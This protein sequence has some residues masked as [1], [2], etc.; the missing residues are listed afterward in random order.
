MLTVEFL[1]PYLNRTLLILQRSNQIPR[2]PKD[3]VRPKIVAGIN[4]LGR[5]QDNESLTR[6]I[7]TV[8]Q[9]LGPD[10][11]MKYIDPSEAIKR[12][13]AAQG[14]D[15]LNLV[16]TPEE[17]QQQ[18][19]A[20]MQ[21]KSQMSLVDQA[22]QLAGTPLMDPAKNPDIADQA[23]TVLSNLQPPQE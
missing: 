6:F 21:D 13:A 9:T 8:A 17:L 11:L 16:R 5:G 2:L 20:M 19:Q 12:L 18:K 3:V 1:V 7:A 23:A 22:G 15:V 4:S 10:A 14:I